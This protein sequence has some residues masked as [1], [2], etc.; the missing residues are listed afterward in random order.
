[1][2]FIKQ[3]KKLCII[4]GIVLIFIIL[5]ILFIR[6]LS[7]DLS[8]NLYGNRL[9][10]INQVKIKEDRMKS[11]DTEMKQLEGVTSVTYDLHGKLV[12]L[13]VT[14]DANLSKDKA[15][16]YANKTLEY[17]KEEE[18]KYYDIQIIFVTKEDSETYP[19]MGY[20]H[21]TSDQYVWKQE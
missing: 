11:M 18:K 2:E 19:M 15:K 8:K 21:K 5:G 7:P 4:L 3:H 6:L 10:G 12:N 1:M 17:F 13:I 16:E 20:K 14:V 9:S